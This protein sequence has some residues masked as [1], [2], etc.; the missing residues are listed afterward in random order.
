VRAFNYYS[1]FRR[2]MRVDFGHLEG[3][4]PFMLQVP[5]Y[6]TQRVLDGCLERL[7]V[8]VERGIELVG[9]S[10]DHKGVKL[11]ASRGDGGR[12]EVSASQ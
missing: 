4:Y 12:Q 1:E 10:H 8:P 2:I 7:G 5:Q 9:L 6:E 11:T 3:P